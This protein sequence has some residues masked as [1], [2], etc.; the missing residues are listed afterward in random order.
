MM[1]LE[2]AYG[3]IGM[4]VWVVKTNRRR[5]RFSGRGRDAREKEQK[6]WRRLYWDHVEITCE[7]HHV[8]I[9]FVTKIKLWILMCIDN[10]LYLL[11]SLIQ[12]YL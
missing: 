12:F 10:L 3:L 8:N 9:S 7:M 6:W 4:T 5:R 11:R 2:K 1:E